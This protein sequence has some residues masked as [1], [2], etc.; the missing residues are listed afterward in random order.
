MTGGR[1]TGREQLGHAMRRADGHRQRRALQIGDL[2][3]M[4]VG[5]GFR[6]C[7]SLIEKAPVK[8]TTYVLRELEVLSKQLG[9]R[10]TTDEPSAGTREAALANFDRRTLATSPFFGLGGAST[11]AFL[12]DLPPFFSACL[13]LAFASAAG[14]S[15]GP[16]SGRSSRTRSAQR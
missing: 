5:N 8:G 15:K 10:R 6:C 11:F 16:S 3:A 1:L 4:G 13:P 7:D 9:N 14:F 2:C 12:T